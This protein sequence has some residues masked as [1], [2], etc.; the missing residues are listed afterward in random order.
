VC[1]IYQLAI[2][3]PA[4]ERQSAKESSLTL[5]STQACPRA[6]RLRLPDSPTVGLTQLG[7]SA[8]LT[9]DAGEGLVGRVGRDLLDGAEAEGKEQLELLG[10]LG[11]LQYDATGSAMTAIVGAK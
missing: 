2:R 1:Q 4:L 10:L 3:S 9:G 5:E 8:K 11:L 7:S 6:S